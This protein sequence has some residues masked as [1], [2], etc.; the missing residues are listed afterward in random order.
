MIVLKYKD[1]YKNN[2]KYKIIKNIQYLTCN[3]KAISQN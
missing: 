2:K 3:K 1:C